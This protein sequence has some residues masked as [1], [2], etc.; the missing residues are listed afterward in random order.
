MKSENNKNYPAT[1]ILLI[2]LF[3]F[4]LHLAVAGNFE[5]HRDELLYFSLGE[6]PAA[7]YASVPPLI[8]WLA[9]I[10]QN[11][12]GYSVYAVRLVPALMSGLMIFLV[13][14]MVK[15]LGGSKYAAILASAGFT[16]AGFGLRTF[17]LFQPVFIDMVF[18]TMIIFLLLR[19]INS[20]NEK[21]LLW[22]GI[23]AGASLLNKYLIGILFLGLLLVLPFTEYRKIFTRKMFWYG[24]IAGFIVFLPNLIWQLV[25][26]FPVLNHL[27]ELNQTQLQNVDRGTF[28]ADQLM[29]PGMAS[30]LTI[31]GILFLFIN[32]KATGYRFL[33]VVMIF[34]VLLLMLLRGKS[35]Y[36]QGIFPFLIAAGA[37][38]FENTLKRKSSRILLP[39]LL[40]FLTIPV[41]PMG[42]PVYKQEKM[43]RYFST[44]ENKYGLVIGRRFE[45]N[46]IHSL[47][48][49][50]ADM[51][52]WEQLTRITDSAYKMIDDKSAAFIYAENYGQAG[53]ITVIGKKY[54]LP[55]A[56]SFSE[57]FR[58]WVPRDFGREI[59][60]GIY[61][62]DE[63]GEDIA[64]LFNN[65]ILVGQITNPDARESGTSVYLCREP[66][67]NFNDFWKR[68]IK[69]LE[70]DN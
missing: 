5:Y 12:F 61:I 35:Y 39:V 51:L 15:Q 64:T 3:N 13:A 38:S 65:I 69:E 45:D 29:N 57:S 25:N 31:A 17:S 20:G 60:A 70:N 19:Y 24:I 50:Y 46:T 18:W 14:G 48:Q 52:G 21:Y 43:V 8:G 6:H 54:G 58:Y 33:G 30:V 62:N 27:S 4:G 2:A 49:D 59:K 53:A 68:R 16:V 37:V 26:G 56:V 23:A 9:W 47:P 42:L 63:L 1:S 40:I 67:V 32:R 34:V 36:T 28:L 66:K 55:Q 7:G 11:I 41:V 44:L 22:F 10:I